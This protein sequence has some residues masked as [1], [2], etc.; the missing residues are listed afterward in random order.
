[1]SQWP[2]ETL[3]MDQDKV[4][5]R[6]TEKVHQ[7]YS[8]CRQDEDSV[9]PLK[10]ERI[11]CLDPASRIIIIA[12]HAFSSWWQK[13]GSRCGL[14]DSCASWLIIAAGKNQSTN[15]PRFHL[16]DQRPSSAFLMKVSAQAL[17]AVG[18]LLI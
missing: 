10:F 18:K 14:N 13:G 8:T 7:Q 11:S 12:D 4:A 6:S 17:Q 9:P 2:A 16:P 5:Q 15:G 3:K 1:M